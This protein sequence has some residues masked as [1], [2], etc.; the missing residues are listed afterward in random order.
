VT[1]RS[2]RFSGRAGETY[3]QALAPLLAAALLLSLSAMIL[4]GA[5]EE[6]V[7][8]A[9][10][11]GLFAA[12]VIGA[13]LTINAPSWRNGPAGHTLDPGP[14][15]MQANIGLAALVY[16]W[17]AL[18]FLAV[19]YLTHLSWRHAWQYGLG[20]ALFAAALSAY[21]RR[22]NGMGRAAMP[23]LTLT[24]LHGLAAALALFYLI[25]TGKL[26]TVKSDWAANDIFLFGG[27]AIV[28]LCAI[29]TTT[30][31]RLAARSA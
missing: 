22:L 26:A 15:L 13:A 3:L 23:P 27:L 24:V 25:G 2:G 7:V 9:V 17:G 8:A 14:R 11:A 18:A 4:G 30:Q 28:A 20:A 29:A 6:R 31:I 5:G 12:V 1:E 21:G 19:Y 16:G 10:A